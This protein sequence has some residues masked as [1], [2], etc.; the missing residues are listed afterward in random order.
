MNKLAAVIGFFIISTILVG[1]PFVAGICFMKGLIFLGICG[2][3]IAL[4][5]IA[6][7]F[8]GF[9]VDNHYF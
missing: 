4:S 9:M 7:L 8:V 1:I 2:G 6:V 3:M 5:E